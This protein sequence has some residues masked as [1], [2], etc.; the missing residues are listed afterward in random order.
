MTDATDAA[1]DPEVGRRILAAWR[2]GTLVPRGPDTPGPRPAEDSGIEVIGV[3][4]SFAAWAICS[5][6]H[7]GV[8][9][10][11]PWRDPEDLAQ[12]LGREIAALRHVPPGLGPLPLALWDDPASSP[13]G[14]PCLVT[15]FVPGRVLA[16]TDWS[17][18][19]LRAHARALARLHTAS[20]PGRGPL[21]GAPDTAGLAPGPM[22]IL[23]EA[24]GAFAWWHEHHPEVADRADVAPLLAA[25]RGRC[26]QAEPAFARND[27]Y[28]LAHGDL[29][30]TNVVWEDD[31]EGAPRPR[32]IDFEWAQA[33]DRA[34]DLAIIGGPVH[35]GPWYVPLDDGALEDLLRTYVD[36]ARGYDPTAI[37]DVDDLR[38]R[39][40]AW[41][42][43]ERTAMLLHVTRRAAEGDPAHRAALPVLRS[44]LAEW[45][46]A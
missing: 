31:A 32:F 10:R 12:P 45:L 42:A 28:V 29:C 35:G 19:H 39:R 2:D 43:Y 36:A 22:S 1:A 17:P 25:A 3:G 20:M 18:R 46:G 21:L 14:R 15:A 40:D 33:D 4:E 27:A 5:P 41:V 23:A 11:V 44:S 13:I 6:G 38:A 8:T 9:V 37:P 26:A 34:R 16:P 7:P 30:A 24:D